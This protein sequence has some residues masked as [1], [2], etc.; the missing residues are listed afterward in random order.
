MDIKKF[1]LVGTALAIVLGGVVG[2]AVVSRQ[3]YLAVIAVVTA[4]VLLRVA[5][6]RVEKVL[7]DERIERVSEKAS[8]RALE[9]FSISAALLSALLIA[10]GN[11]TGYILGF[12]VCAILILYLGFY[13]FYSRSSV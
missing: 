10:L 11:S 6:G 8:R 2:Y 5:R 9:L 4:L 13:A 12:S 7:L 3:P 1:A